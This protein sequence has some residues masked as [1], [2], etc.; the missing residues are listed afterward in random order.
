M[1]YFFLAYNLNLA[2][3]GNGKLLSHLIWWILYAYA[4]FLINV[5]VGYVLLSTLAT[6]IEFV[7]YLLFIS[8]V[9]D[10]DIYMEIYKDKSPHQLIKESKNNI[11]LEPLNYPNDELNIKSYTQLIQMMN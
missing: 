7:A 3:K 1:S 11:S 2:V 6:I 5:P 10:E 4:F 9:E 8:L